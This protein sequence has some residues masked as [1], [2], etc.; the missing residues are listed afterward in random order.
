[1]DV[2]AFV[3]FAVNGP[4][5][6]PVAVEDLRRFREIFGPDLNLAWDDARGRFQRAQLGRAVEAF[7]ANGGVRAWVVRVAGAEAASA[8]FEL[9]GLVNAADGTAAML[10]ARAPGAWADALQ[11]DFEIERR[12]LPAAPGGFAL[13]LVAG[14]VELDLGPAADGPVGGDVVEIV[15][16][17]ESFVAFLPVERIAPLPDG[18]RAHCAAPAWAEP[19]PPG[20]TGLVRISDAAGSARFAAW[21]ARS[22]APSAIASLLRMILRARIGD[23]AELRLDD[24]GLGRGHPRWFG[25]LPD[26]LELSAPDPE[27][28]G[29][30]RDAAAQ[31]FR[32][33]AS[34]PRFSLAGTSLSPSASGI[35][36]PLD[37]AQRTS[38]EPVS[39]GRDGL[40]AFAAELFLDP[41]LRGAG[42][43]AL[44][45]E[46]EQ[47]LY[48]RGEQAMGLHA[49]WPLSEVALLAIPDAGHRRW[50]RLAPP[51]EG[52][53]AAPSLQLPVDASA[54]CP[55]AALTWTEVAGAQEYLVERAQHAD[56]AIAS[57]VFRGTAGAATVALRS[58]CPELVYFRVRAL[59]AGVVGPWSNTRGARLPEEDAQP[60]ALAPARHLSLSAAP[61]GSPGDAILFSW[62]EQ[63]AS[64]ATPV[65]IEIQSSFDASF[66][67]PE[68]VFTGLAAEWISERPIGTARYFRARSAKAGGPHP[69]SSTVIVAP[70]PRSDFSLEPERGF[71][72][73]DLLAIHRAALRFAAARSDLTVTLSLPRHYC[74]EETL[75]HLAALQPA[76]GTSFADIVA[77]VPPLTLGEHRVLSYGG[78][79]H[80]WT[81]SELEGEIDSVPPDG[82]VTGQAAAVARSEG[83][84]IVPANRPF[85]GVLGLT[86][87]FNAGARLRF[88]SAGM[89]P[90]VRGT[91]G[92]LTRSDTTM[93]TDRDLRLMNVRRL[94]ILL[95]RLALRE[96]SAV[97]F[98]PHNDAF[99]A[100]VR[101][102]M[103]QALGQMYLRGAF[104]GATAEQAF[105]VI[106]DAVLNPRT[107]VE[108]GRFIVELRVA[109]TKPLAFLRILLLQT[110]PGS[111]MVEEV[112]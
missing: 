43:G 23:G 83:A 35:F 40:D 103:E 29:P 93:S 18:L 88:E 55:A 104:R 26:D 2:A 109:P 84:W 95:R 59:A 94:M 50:R 110:G 20:A 31:A 79:F 44:A 85:A 87:N 38:L 91:R 30:P 15:F 49:L 27:E 39:P 53:L 60:C 54:D 13:R 5:G 105:A 76:A 22:P 47:K 101:R 62:S 66:T 24:L 7:F 25:F 90:L 16:S 82:V 58:P 70:A 3:G 45:G 75:T 106:A 46:A 102:R 63:D 100:F 68:T 1:M 51:V 42:L 81:I 28:F 8:R 41:D 74:E 61:A 4:V 32:A 33:A 71:E 92:F 9:P 11:A 73:A 86:Q 65:A 12:R 99:R 56:F 78:L 69:W 80:P 48:F 34:Q 112:A 67:T 107:S 111:V 52:L 36:L 6:L 77:E 21:Q 19:A 64:P 14:G 89:N 72:G 37:M 57:E 96:G 97:V 17:G 98:E 10:T 108:A